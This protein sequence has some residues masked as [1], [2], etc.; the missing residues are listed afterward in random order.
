[1]VFVKDDITRK[2]II[3]TILLELIL[4]K[5]LH[6]GLRE[7]TMRRHPHN[8][9][10][11]NCSRKRYLQFIMNSILCYLAIYLSPFTISYKFKTLPIYNIIFSIIVLFF[12]V[13]INNNQ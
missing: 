11:R 12:L 8:R 7:K 5:M 9:N 6:M 2:L 13:V 3:K 1:M 10:C 4:S